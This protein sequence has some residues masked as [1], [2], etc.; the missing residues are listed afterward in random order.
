MGWSCESMVGCDPTLAPRCYPD[1]GAGC[2]GIE[3][4]AECVFISS[5]EWRCGPGTLEESTC[6]AFEPECGGCETLAEVACEETVGC[7]PIYDD[8]CCSTCEPGGPCADCTRPVFHH[9]ASIGAACA[10]DPPVGC[11]T[12]AP[13]TCASDLPDCS[14][15]NPVDD[16]RCDLPGCITAVDSLCMEPCARFCIPLHEGLCTA[17]C[18]IPEPPCPAGFGAE[19]EGGCYTGRCIGLEICSPSDI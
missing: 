10:D 2:C 19:A 15:A 14:L 18:D 8:A 9:C 16:T 13:W 4:P 3:V 1:L 7:A 17:L 5:Y 6:A 11:G 12:P